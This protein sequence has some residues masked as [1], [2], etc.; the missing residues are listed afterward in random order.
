MKRNPAPLLYESMTARVAISRFLAFW[1]ETQRDYVL[2][3]VAKIHR[4]RKEPDYPSD[5]RDSRHIKSVARITGVRYNSRDGTRS[6]LFTADVV[7]REAVM[8]FL[9]V[10]AVVGA[11]GVSLVSGQAVQAQQ[12]ESGVAADN[13]K[14]LP[15]INLQDFDGKAV[16]ADDLKGNIV[17][18]DF[19]ATWC[20]P[21]IT[22]IPT[23]NRLQEK[24]AAKGVKIVGVTLASGEAKEVKPF[25]KRNKMKYTVLMGDD[26]QAYDFNVMAFPTTY[27]VTRDLKVFRRYIGAGPRKA[28]QIE[29]DIQTLLAK[30]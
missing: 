6:K 17:V 8:K 2:R 29:A 25:V 14:P 3:Q 15:A 7:S 22:E 10:L 19:W 13:L 20:G 12:A 16:P 27:L 30:N 9:L 21:C 11:L 18:L 23:L 1:R 5:S 26:D 24:Y 28:A 4:V